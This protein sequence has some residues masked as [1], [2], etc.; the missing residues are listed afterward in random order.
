MPYVQFVSNK[1][2]VINKVFQA[3]LNFVKNYKSSSISVFS[4]G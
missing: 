2:G 1:T 4:V 3:N